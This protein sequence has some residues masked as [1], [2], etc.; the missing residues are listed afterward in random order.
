MSSKLV[1]PTTICPALLVFCNASSKRRY[2]MGFLL[3]AENYGNTP[4]YKHYSSLF[5]I[6]LQ[7]FL[8]N[9][10][11]FVPGNKKTVALH[12]QSRFHVP[13]PLLHS[14]MTKPAISLTCHSIARV[15]WFI[16]NPA[17]IHHALHRSLNIFFKKMTYACIAQYNT[18]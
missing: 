17:T 5:R 6:S 15:F 4:N 16:L 12:F 2:H 7:I 9:H 18:I 8:K 11:L 1:H 14:L 10:T 13:P 3:L